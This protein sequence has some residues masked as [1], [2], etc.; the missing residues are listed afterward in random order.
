MA[1]RSGDDSAGRLRLWASLA[2]VYAVWGSTYLAIRVM[3][4]TIPP[5][6]GAGTRFIVA[7]AALSAWI[8]I[9]GT[10]RLA[11]MS[12][13]QIANAMFAGILVLA[14][15]I[16]LVTVA[17]QDVPSGL[18]AVIIASIPL[19]VVLI[20]L[21]LGDR[22]AKGTAVAVALGF[23]GLLALFWPT[24]AP[25][26]PTESMLLLV[27]AAALTAVGIVYSSRS[28]MPPNAFVGAAIEMVTAG[29]VLLVAATLLGELAMPSDLRPSAASISA[30]IYLVTMGSIVAY[31]CFVWLLD[32]ASV[33][34]V[35]T[36][37]YVNPIVAVLAGFAFL[38]ERVT[39]VM[40][41]ATVIVLA[42]VLLVVRTEPS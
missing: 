32:N 36:Y 25:T 35:A 22:A 16:G 19:W 15:G 11:A 29:S 23:I 33:S 5:L 28:D 42:S 12:P 10:S 38:G 27:A 18:A 17:E 41:T 24:D 14:G 37:A 3:V 39:L 7:G 2:T 31:S 26:A 13:A 40:M 9:R 6:L 1:G 34:T 30:L 8:A 21:L 20:R 4:R